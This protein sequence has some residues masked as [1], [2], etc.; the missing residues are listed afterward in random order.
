MN[1]KTP[2]EKQLELS[3]EDEVISSS[4]NKNIFENKISTKK[5][6]KVKHKDNDYNELYNEESESIDNLEKIISKKKK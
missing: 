1:T 3:D 2:L 5:L 6:T 4:K